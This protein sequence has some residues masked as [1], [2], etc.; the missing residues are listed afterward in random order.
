M[1]LDMCALYDLV[2]FSCNLTSGI[3]CPPQYF[4]YTPGVKDITISTRPPTTMN[5]HPLELLD[6][7]APDKGSSGTAPPPRKRD[8]FRKFFSIPK[9]LAKVKAKSSTQSLTSQQSTLWSDS[10]QVDDHRNKTLPIAQT[11]ELRRSV[12][13]PENVAKPSVKTAL[14]GLQ[15]R[16]DRIDQLLYCHMLLRQDS[17]VSSSRREGN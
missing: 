15:E 6:D 11:D 17:V 7:T 10:S 14:P 8:K 2:H 5:N 1:F 16:I 4:Q 12:I 9:S 13:F 3:H